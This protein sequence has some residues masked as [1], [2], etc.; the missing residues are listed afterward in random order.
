MIIYWRLQNQL[1]P[2]NYNIIDLC[3]IILTLIKRRHLFLL[4][5]IDNTLRLKNQG[6]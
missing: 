5:T 3:I 2:V 4:E 6:K 1:Q